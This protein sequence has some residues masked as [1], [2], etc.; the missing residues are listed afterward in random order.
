MR[1]TSWVIE[2]NDGIYIA[3]NNTELHFIVAVTPE[4]T[5][6]KMVFNESSD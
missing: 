5:E 3:Q 1:Y 4:D 2:R 6:I